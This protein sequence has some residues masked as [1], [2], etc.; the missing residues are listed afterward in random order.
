MIASE[1]F[2]QLTFRSKATNRGRLHK[3]KFALA[4]KTA[5]KQ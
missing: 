1:S 5:E 4:T 2:D 3:N